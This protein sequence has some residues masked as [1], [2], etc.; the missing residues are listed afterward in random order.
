M[1]G[2]AC[3]DGTQGARLL[4]ALLPALPIST[5]PSCSSWEQSRGLSGILLPLP[6]AR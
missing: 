6:G 5:A 2:D 4:G 1:S 3:R